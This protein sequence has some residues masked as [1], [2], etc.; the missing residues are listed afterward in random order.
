MRMCVGIDDINLYVAVLSGQTLFAGPLTLKIDR[1]TLR[2]LKYDRRHL[3]TLKST[4][5]FEK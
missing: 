1:A 4:G 3:I 5:T 2:L